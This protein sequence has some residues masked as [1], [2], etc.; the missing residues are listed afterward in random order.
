MRRLVLSNTFLLETEEDV[1]TL[2]DACRGRDRPVTI[3]ITVRKWSIHSIICGVFKFNDCDGQV[4]MSLGLAGCL[5][6][7]GD[8]L[9]PEQA[10][11]VLPEV[12]LRPG[13]A[14]EEVR[15]AACRQH[16]SPNCSGP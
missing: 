10:V 2:T 7:V 9:N 12:L 11:F 13:W 3:A 1:T 6:K 4:L 5:N 14:L 8:E 16:Y 15:T